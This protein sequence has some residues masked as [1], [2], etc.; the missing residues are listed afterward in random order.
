LIRYLT[1]AEDAAIGQ[2][3]RPCTR[4][5]REYHFPTADTP[6]LTFLDTR[7]VEE[8]GYDPA[9]DL[10]RFDD[11]AHIVVVTV[12]LL[13]QAQ[14]AI[15]NHL[16]AL[17]KSQPSRPVLLVLTCLHEA[18]PQQQHPLPYPYDRGDETAIP[19]TVRR[20]IDRHKER[21]EGLFDRVVPVDLTPKEEGFNDPNYGGEA[22]RQALVDLLPS[23]YRQTLLALDEAT[24][25][26]ADLHE[27]LALPHILGYSM[28]AASA[29]AIPI[30]WLDLLL[31]PGIQS[32]MIHAL[33]R[34]Y[35]QPLNATRFLEIAGTLGAG[36]VFRQATRE[37]TKFIP[38]FGSV[39]SSALAGASTFALGKAFCFYYRAV[40]R[41]HVPS[42]AELNHYYKDQLALA[43]KHWAQLKAGGNGR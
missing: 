4:F 14:E 26:L 40:H 42:T 23:A 2:G 1:G 28:L 7:G 21:F 9:E 13:D 3:F 5:S 31:L 34:L 6:L 39:A 24:H 17:R 15:V 22:L 41:G 33:A 19:E 12:K 43:K 32:Q 10:A 36:L 37:L 25:E 16:K 20:A 18:Y 30:P 38:I 27:K 8:P 29:G 11:Q 35:G